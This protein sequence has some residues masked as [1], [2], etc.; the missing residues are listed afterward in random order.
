MEVIIIH[1]AIIFL[2]KRLYYSEFENTGNKNQHK[3]GYSFY[4]WLESKGLTP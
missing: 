3:D 2:L 4:E 1:K